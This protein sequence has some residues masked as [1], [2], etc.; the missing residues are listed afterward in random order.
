MRQDTEE[1]T[2]SQQG[3]I[4]V[5]YKILAAKIVLGKVFVVINSLNSFF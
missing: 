2:T 1:S 5:K 3:N 4:A